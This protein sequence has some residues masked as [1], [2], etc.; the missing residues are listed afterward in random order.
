MKIWLKK[1][2]WKQIYDF[3]PIGLIFVKTKAEIKTTALINTSTIITNGSAVENKDIIPIIHITT[4]NTGSI[5][6]IINIQMFPTLMLDDSF[7]TGMN[8][9]A[10]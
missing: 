4:K 2:V 5:Y 8:L 10:P 6:L 7:K 3:P 1:E 9:S